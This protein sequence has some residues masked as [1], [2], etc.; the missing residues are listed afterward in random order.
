MGI[1]VF[2]IIRVLRTMQEFS[3]LGKIVLVSI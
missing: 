2:D 1:F 3:N